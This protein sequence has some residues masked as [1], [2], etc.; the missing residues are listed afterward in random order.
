MPSSLIFCEPDERFYTTGTAH[1]PGV[2][3]QASGGDAQTKL[4]RC[5]FVFRLCFVG[6]VAQLIHSP[7]I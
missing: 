3:V 1:G 4:R 5:D 2:V 7:A 6:P